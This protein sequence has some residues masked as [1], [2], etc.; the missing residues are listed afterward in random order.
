MTET[1]NVTASWEDMGDNETIPNPAPT[2]ELGVTGVKRTGGYMDEEF[3]PAL[4]GRK[5]VKVFKEMYLN[6]SMVGALMFAIDKL[7]REVEWKVTPVDQTEENIKAAEFVE[8]CM[9]DMSHSWDDFIGEVLS[10]LV[11]GWSWHEIVY[12]RR[13]GPWEKD[14]SKRSKHTDGLIGWRKMPIRSQETLFRWSF[15]ENGGIKGMIQMAPPKYTQTALPI[16]KCLLFRTSMAKGNPEGHSLLRQAYRSWYFKKRLEEFEAIGVERDLA[17]MPVAKVPS[18]YLSAKPGTPQHKTVEAYKKMVRGVRRDENEGLVLPLAYDPDTKQPLFEFEL[19]GAGGSRQFDTNG[20]IQRYEQRILMSVLADFILVGHEQTGSYSLH[21]DKTG[22]F[23]A[24][25]NA[26]VKSI[27]DTLNRHAVPRLF[28]VNGM[29]LDKLPTFEPTN[30]DPPD[31]N[32][33]A[34]FISA[35]A[36]A[37][38]QWFPDPELEKF[39]REIAR[40]PEMSEDT[41]DFKRE[42]LEQNQAMEFATSQMGLLGLKQKAEMTAQGYSPEQAEMAAQQPN[43]EMSQ[44]QA[45]AEQEGEAMRRMHPVGQQD[46]EQHEMQ[47]AK[48]QEKGKADPEAMAL[49]EQAEESKFGR[50]TERMSLQEQIEQ[51]KHQRTMEQMGAKEKAEAARAQAQKGQIKRPPTKG[52]EK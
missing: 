37:G 9:E 18:E 30:V 1:R 7:V 39:V 3:L 26:I 36:G 14:G 34:S 31:L 33:L 27:A 5:A 8:S 42:L 22:I 19:M 6:D 52:K 47:Q 12:K 23:R 28:E 49:Q 4:R 43:A 10:C 51:K 50:E 20:I 16:E 2:V 21:T 15:D 38:M 41:V 44:H 29:K 40:L 24:A 13:L 11:Y 32:Q 35:T 25:L 48:E 46:Q 17:G 45:L